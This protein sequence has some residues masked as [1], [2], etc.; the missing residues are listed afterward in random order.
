MK[1]E[2]TKE[3]VMALTSADHARVKAWVKATDKTREVITVGGS[4]LE[5][6]IQGL[7]DQFV[8]DDLPLS[9][10]F[11]FRIN[12]FKTKK[13]PTFK[14]N[15]DSFSELLIEMATKYADYREM[16][17]YV[18]KLAD[19]YCEFGYQYEHKSDIS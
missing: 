4:E 15:L 18:L 12:E 9:K 13:Y 1:M 14:D 11:E 8:I 16:G 6:F 19:I 5:Q 17:D 3:Q 7:T 2:L 10:H